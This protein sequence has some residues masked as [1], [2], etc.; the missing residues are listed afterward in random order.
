MH[1]W[2]HLRIVEGGRHSFPF[3]VVVRYLKRYVRVRL[4]EEVGRCFLTMDAVVYF[5][6]TFKIDHKVVIKLGRYGRS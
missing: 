1:N 2:R 5:L 3:I 4:P 6:I